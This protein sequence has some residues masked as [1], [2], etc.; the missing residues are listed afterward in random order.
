[1]EN[2]FFD[3]FVAKN[4]KTKIIFF[5]IGLIFVL[6]L[7]LILDSHFSINGI[8]I[9][10]VLV[11][12][13]LTVFNIYFSYTILLLLLFTPHLLSLHNS[14][15]FTFFVAIT[16]IFTYS[17]NFIYRL[18]KKVLYSFLI[19]F[20]STIPSL[21]VTAKPLNSLF[22]ATNLFA[23]LVVMI[24]TMLVI[25][26]SK[27][28]MRILYF[29]IFAVF[30]HSIIV[31]YQG[32]TTGDRVFGLLGVFFVD[33]AG[34]GTLLSI[35]LFF[36]T[37]GVKK[38][39]FGIIS[40]IILLALIFTQTRNAW[41]SLAVSFVLLI[42]YLVIHRKKYKMN[43]LYISL[44]IVV[45]SLG[46]YFS[47][48]VVSKS[49]YSVEKRLDVGSQTLQLSKN[50]PKGG[51]NSF[52]SRIL[53]WHTAFEAFLEYPITGIGLYSFKYTSGEYYKIPKNFYEEFVEGRTPHVT[54]IEVLA[55]TG[56]IG[57][58][59]FSFFIFTIIR[60]IVSSLKYSGSKEDIKRT[61][62]ICWSF[63]YIIFSMAMT[64]AWLYGQYLI[65]FGI[66]IGLLSNNQKL[67]K[68]GNKSFDFIG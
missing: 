61:L 3:K 44:V 12:S 64:E 46:T 49:N 31:I 33:L 15:L 8:L 5:V 40:L 41:L 6:F 37:D 26:T 4:N 7:A 28:I 53:I 13:F 42:I 54:Y 63:V 51:I 18:D 21:F 65:W 52:I 50:T 66:L 59:G 67:L 34:L 25:D 39:F 47:F 68:K 10:L 27:M 55:E 57:F 1:M 19:Y 20:L 62:L 29:F 35:I 9:I 32:I 43:A 17:G 11:L 2:V 24:T 22:E 16:L 36:Q 45:L 60:L 23:F 30:I 58:I 48:S 56:V 38:L 14:I